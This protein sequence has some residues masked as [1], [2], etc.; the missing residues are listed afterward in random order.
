[1]KTTESNKLIA[2]F[3]YPDWIHPKDMKGAPKDLLPLVGDSY[4]VLAQ[5]ITKDYEALKYHSSWNSLMPVVEKIELIEDVNFVFTVS[6][7]GFIKNGNPI[8][9]IGSKESKLK[10]TFESVVEFINW[11][12]QRLSK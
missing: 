12:N 2:E 3:M 8:C 10:R 9:I 4:F 6:Q 5:L 1:M 7:I 11:H